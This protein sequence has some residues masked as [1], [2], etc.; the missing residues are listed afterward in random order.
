MV[1]LE[2]SKGLN[3]NK[4]E[5]TRQDGIDGPGIKLRYW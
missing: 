2:Y 3:S 1:A 5:V 4:N